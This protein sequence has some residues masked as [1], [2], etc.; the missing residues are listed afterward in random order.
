MPCLVSIFGTVCGTGDQPNKNPGALFRCMAD[1]FS[2]ITDHEIQRPDMLVTLEI[3]QV[4]HVR[5][6]NDWHNCRSSRKL[7][8]HIQPA[9][10][11]VHFAV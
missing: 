5:C 10:A 1:I 9:I 2:S 11:C 3:G 4:G 8:W 6:R 7:I